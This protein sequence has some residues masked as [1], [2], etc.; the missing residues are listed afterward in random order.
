MNPQ[1][2]PFTE[3]CRTFRE[4][5]GYAESRFDSRFSTLLLA[6]DLNGQTRTASWLWRMVT[7]AKDFGGPTVAEKT[8]DRYQ[9]LVLGTC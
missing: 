4:L 6:L 7:I 5:G 9:G 3:V 8:L 1:A 2:P